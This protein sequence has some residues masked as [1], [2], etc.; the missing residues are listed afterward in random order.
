MFIGREHELSTL[1]RL[2][3]SDG[4]QF[5]VVYGR[6]RV[7]KTT[8]IS[9]FA[10]GKPTIFFTAIEN[11]RQINLRNLSNAIAQFEHP[12]RD[13]KLAAVYTDF[14]QAF[15]VIFALAQEERIVFVIDELSCQ[16]RLKRLVNLA[17]AD[18]QQSR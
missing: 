9:R 17:V 8:L 7:G 12:D 5:P 13:P 16:G 15:E 14:Q 18:R 11:D 4:F 3:E 10:S 1:K 6:R 2:Y